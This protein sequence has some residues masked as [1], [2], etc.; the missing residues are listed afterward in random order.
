MTDNDGGDSKAQDQF[1]PD[2][3]DESTESITA[4]SVLS[5]IRETA[6]H[7]LAEAR[8]E[9]SRAKDEAWQRYQ[10][11]TKYRRRKD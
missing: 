8:A 9:A 7:M 11:K 6:A 1:E 2:I 3:S 5:G 4:R 10:S